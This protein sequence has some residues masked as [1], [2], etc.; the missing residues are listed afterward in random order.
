[1][2]TTFLD[3]HPDSH[4][5]FSGG[6][7]S[8]ACLILLSLMGRKDVPVFTQGDDLDWP[9]KRAHC[10]EVVRRLGFTDYSYD[11]PE[12]SALDEFASKDFV[13]NDPLD[14]EA[15]FFSVI[16]RYEQRRNLTGAILGLRAEESR[17]RR[18]NFFRKGAI[19]QVQGGNWRCLPIARWSGPDVFALIV[20]TGTPWFHIYDR[21]D[22]CPPHE[23][24]LAWMCNPPFVTG[25]AAAFLYRH[26]PEQFERLNRINPLLR[27]YLG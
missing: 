22:E 6:K 23:R 3:E 12:V 2:L 4:L 5:S 21:D 25:G 8:T 27:S 17:H 19:Y 20:S 9:D 11:E 7:D 18:M 15:L 16:R 13:H 14:N 1:M 26:Y 24:R 10:H